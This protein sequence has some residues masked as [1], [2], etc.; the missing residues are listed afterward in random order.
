MPRLRHTLLAAVVLLGTGVDRSVAQSPHP[1]AYP[2]SI[3][4][5]LMIPSGSGTLSGS[6]LVP[7][8]P[9]PYPA[10]VVLEGSGTMSFRRSW[11]PE[12][13]PFWKDIA[14]HLRARGYAVLLFD[15][16]GVHRSSGD[17]R[18]QSFEDRTE[19]ALAVVRYLAARPEIDR[20][21][22]GLLGHSQGGWIAQL[23]AAH[24]PEE[25]AF[26][27]SLA[28][29][30][31]SVKQQIQDDMQSS[32]SCQGSSGAGRWARGAGLRVGLGTLG[33]VARVAKPSY[34]ARIINYDPRSVLSRM[35]RPMLALFA[36]DDPLVLAEPNRARLEQYFG[37]GQ[38][39]AHL[40]VVTVPGANHF[41][42]ASPRCPEPGG[43]AGWAPGFF[44]A[45]DDPRFW[46]QIQA[47]SD[48]NPQT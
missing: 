5:E 46:Q 17:W 33:L 4:E 8:G 39:D 38:R 14:E 29:P 15:K 42:R 7:E 6:L 34:L 45:L 21:R 41:F 40:E 25:V 19:D 43:N 16:A 10:V 26:V 27:I 11:L 44:K 36:E 1:H 20:S 13:F 3:G 9:G 18:R 12:F 30:S 2:D 22:I 23:A 48:M 24:A 32:W 47:S 31:V 35:R 28:G 37:A